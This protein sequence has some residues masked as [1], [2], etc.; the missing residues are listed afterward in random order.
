MDD[1]DSLLQDLQRPSHSEP[2]SQTVNLAELDDLMT[3]L[4]DDA[5]KAPKPAPANELD[6]LLNDLSLGSQAASAKPAPKPAPAAK[7][8]PVAKPAPKQSDDLDD[9][10]N[11]LDAPAPAPKAAAP[12]PQP[13]PAAA[14]PPPAAVAVD[15]LDDLLDGL[16]QPAPRAGGG[17]G[18]GGG[19][20][21][22]DD[23]DS[24]LN[25]INS[26]SR[27]SGANRPA[28]SNNRAPAPQNE[29]SGPSRGMCSGCNQPVRGEV[30]QA[31]GGFWHVN[32]F[33][34]GNCQ[35]PLGSATFYEY[36]GQPHCE[37]CY[38]GMFC[39]R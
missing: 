21:G 12:Q 3:D 4:Q 35:E 30:M 9:L 29:S 13:A 24:L 31:L 34:C 5:R 10:L 26:A 7:P 14:R 8:A 32:C 19:R 23:V 2:D 36:E 1:L 6:D 11:D 25:D 38:K 39:P 22:G 17:G 16:D 27:S 28:A 33:A 37:K 15:D 20:G 18:G